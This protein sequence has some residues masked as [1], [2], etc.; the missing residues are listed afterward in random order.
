[1]KNAPKD[2]DNNIYVD[3]IILTEITR[4]AT[5]RASS[6]ATYYAL[7][8]SRPDYWLPIDRTIYLPRIAQAFQGTRK[9]KDALK[10][11]SELSFACFPNHNTQ[12]P[13]P[14]IFLVFQNTTTA[15]TASKY[16]TA[17]TRILSPGEVSEA[18]EILGSHGLK[19][20]LARLQPLA[21]V[22]VLVR[23]VDKQVI[24]CI[25]SNDA[26]KYHKYFQWLLNTDVYYDPEC[27]DRTNEVTLI[28]DPDCTSRP[29]T[30]GSSF[31]DTGYREIDS[32]ADMV[33]DGI[34]TM[35]NQGNTDL[36]ITFAFHESE[37]TE[38][39]RS[40][41]QAVNELEIVDVNEAH[42]DGKIDEYRPESSRRYK[43]S[44]KHDSNGGSIA[45]GRGLRGSEKEN[46]HR[47]ENR[48][49]AERFR[50]DVRSTSVNRKKEQNE[51]ELYLPELLRLGNGGNG[52]GG[53]LGA[54]NRWCRRR[55]KR[56]DRRAKARKGKSTENQTSGSNSKKY[57]G[58]NSEGNR[59]ING[60]GNNKTKKDVGARTKMEYR[61]K[62][63][64]VESLPRSFKSN[65]PDRNTTDDTNLGS[66][67]QQ[68]KH[69]Q[70]N[71]AGRSYNAPQIA[72]IPD[73]TLY[74]GTQVHD[75]GT[76]ACKGQNYEGSRRK[77]DYYKKG[78][79]RISLE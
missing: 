68:L 42:F 37:I 53:G 31:G 74:A 9:L 4:Q 14:S 22:P 19:E 57:S 76:S 58:N 44:P 54:I 60:T 49:T 33:S 79:K 8:F 6:N 5:S 2:I 26:G 39:L 45:R 50:G 61:Q 65:R 51:A 75:D 40:Q 3:G 41:L 64:K 59:M 48:S 10:P 71:S 38:R 11:L 16:L 62:N 29:F 72:D 67:D 73:P 15:E 12:Q 78:N 21:K 23:V 52:N 20:H 30:S 77:I 28:L 70:G 24:L 66:Q 69:T 32:V 47:A 55:G 7:Y 25:G 13:S 46:I 18:P 34:L 43:P 1:M 35:L 63:E 27:F 17:D 36:A 56:G